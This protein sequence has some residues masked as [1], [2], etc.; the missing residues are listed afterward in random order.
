MSPKL[1]KMKNRADTLNKLIKLD[2]YILVLIGVIFIISFITMIFIWIH[3]VNEFMSSSEAT[4]FKNQAIAICEMN[5]M[6]FRNLYAK[7]GEYDF[8][9][10]INYADYEEF[11]FEENDK[12]KC[13]DYYD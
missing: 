6:K 10:Y 3:N 8:R 11:Y 2:A 12:E 4:C 7:N 5:K 9:C 1:K 13:G